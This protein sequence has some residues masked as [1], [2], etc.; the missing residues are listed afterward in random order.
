VK[1]LLPFPH[2]LSN[3]LL[4][5]ISLFLLSFFL[6]FSLT[7]CLSSYFPIT[8]TDLKQKETYSEMSYGGRYADYDD[9]PSRR[10]APREEVSFR[11]RNS[12][13]ELTYSDRIN[14]DTKIS[15]QPLLRGLESMTPP[16]D[17]PPETSLFPSE[18]VLILLLADF[19]LLLPEPKHLLK[20]PLLEV[21]HLPQPKRS[22]LYRST[23]PWPAGSNDLK[24]LI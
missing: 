11:A 15:P 4:F 1:H 19:N 5:L 10:Q 3:H 22:L 18:V 13:H 12:R 23:P 14:H 24:Y 21:S 7:S 17:R 8:D 16:L 2:F 6:S 9:E 20:V